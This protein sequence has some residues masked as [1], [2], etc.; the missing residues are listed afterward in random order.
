MALRILSLLMTLFAVASA[1]DEAPAK[2]G[3]ANTPFGYVIE[4]DKR[5]KIYNK[6]DPLE[7]YV[8]KEEC[9]FFY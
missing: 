8:V 1:Q 2:S 6:T 7:G 3:A 9:N 5:P 4:V